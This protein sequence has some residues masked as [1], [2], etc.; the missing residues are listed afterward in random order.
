M[1]SQNISLTH[2]LIGYVTS[3][4]DTGQYASVSE[5]HREAI[6]HLM[7]KKEIERLQRERINLLLEQGERDLKEGKV[8]RLE[9]E[10]ELDQFF[11]ELDSEL[12]NEIQNGYA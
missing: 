9:D 6:R 10:A 4:V 3:L 12:S 5:V 7:E 8:I 1:P 2:D 11:N